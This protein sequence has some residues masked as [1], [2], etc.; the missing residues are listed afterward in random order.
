MMAMKEKNNFSWQQQY[1]SAN[2]NKQQTHYTKINFVNESIV[3]AKSIHETENMNVHSKGDTFKSMNN[4]HK[5][6]LN[7]HMWRR[8]EERKTMKFSR[9]FH[10]LQTL[11]PLPYAK[12]P[13]CVNETKS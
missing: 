7:K 3:S 2:N 1:K 11:T 13:E 8:I 4:C 12:T 9:K 5:V 6:S 10:L